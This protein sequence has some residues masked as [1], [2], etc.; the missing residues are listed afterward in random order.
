MALSRNQNL[1]LSI[2]G[3]FL[4]YIISGICEEV[5]NQ[6]RE[7]LINFLLNIYYYTFLVFKFIIFQYI[8]SFTSSNGEKF[9]FSIFLLFILCLTNCVV[10]TVGMLV[11]PRSN[12]QPSSLQCITTGFRCIN[13]STHT[14]PPP[15]PFPPPFFFK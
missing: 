10:A 11:F 14:C 6:L 4:S 7:I 8:Y 13:Y 9:T 2:L 15:P 1:T 5:C 3:L 12:R